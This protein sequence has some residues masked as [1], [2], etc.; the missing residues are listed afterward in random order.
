MT[1]IR[2]GTVAVLVTLLLSITSCNRFNAGPK[3][4]QVVDLPS[5]I[6][7]SRDEITKMVGAPPV[8]DDTMSVA[9][10]LPEGG[11]SLSK[12]DGQISYSLKQSYSAFA[13]SR[14]MAEL[15][16]VNV[17]TRKVRHGLGWDSYDHITVNGKTFDLLILREGRGYYD[18]LISKFEIGGEVAEHF[19][20]TQVVDLPSMIG[21]SREEIEKMVGIPAA[22]EDSAGIHWVLPEGRVKVDKITPG[23]ISYNLKS[24]SDF[25]PD[26]GVASPEEMAALVNIDIQGRQPEKLRDGIVAYRNL[27]VNGKTLDLHIKQSDNRYMDA[28]IENF[29]D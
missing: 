20:P 3:P 9:W 12:N 10:A 29:K 11:L 21:K 14:E 15:V 5:F 26:R 6:G 24:Y 1:L 28:W 25:A 19:K 4:T 22:R 2:L 27:S 18:A 8:K 17:Q 7:K 16:K 13:S 23:S